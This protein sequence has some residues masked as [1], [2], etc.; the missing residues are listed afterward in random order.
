MSM[1]KGLFINGAWQ[2][3]QGKKI[4]SFNPA[5]NQEVWQGAMADATQ[6]QQAVV[7]AQQSTWKTLSFDERVSFL[8]KFSQCLANKKT[9]LAT[10]ISQE[11]GKP[12]WESA[13]E[14]AAMLGKLDISIS[15]AQARAGVRKNSMP[16]AM[17]I[18]RHQPHGV[19]AIL[20]PYNFP[21]HLPNGHIIPALLAGNSVVFKPSELTPKTA[22]MMV[23]CW[24][25]VQLPSGAI[26][27]I[28]GDGAI[29]QLLLEQPINGVLFTGSYKTGKKIHQQFAGRPEV[30]LA[31]EM[32]GNN[33]LLV[34]RVE[35]I[36]AAV[37]STLLS[38]YMTAGQRCTCARR[39]IIVDDE[40]GQQFLA[41]LT[42]G[43]KNITVGSYQ[44]NPEPFMGPVI[45]Q[46]VAEQLLNVQ[47][48]LI[49]QGARAMVSM[50]LL[51]PESGLL[52]PGLIDT[53]DIARED[54][55]Y[56]GPLLQVIRCQSFSEALE[57]ANQTCYGLAA[58]LF[59]DDKACYNQFK[60]TVKAGIVN[61]NR[62]LTGAS[63]SAPFGG[64][65]YSGNH[66]PSAYYA[67]DY[68]AYPVASLEAERLVLPRHLLSGIA[69]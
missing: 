56:F 17:S 20:G 58:G 43:V 9:E 35:D 50:T 11:A 26:N 59:S 14:V 51:Q 24:E 57:V 30:I 44:Q 18:T 7:A 28:Q 62:P 1:S 29:A 60:Q 16:D 22:E 45:S 40:Q 63:S 55:E 31:L 39:L 21:G 38:A 33:P 41:A 5:N 23:D 6:V 13:T 67:A 61:C 49:Q 4:V 69:L 3:G 12:L 32:G 34:H 46:T 2:P 47:S 64:I 54:T 48:K 27:L 19:L 52:S 10:V 8:K 42:Q 37:Y 53:T 36:P 68:C 25:E 65:G 15:A 66:R